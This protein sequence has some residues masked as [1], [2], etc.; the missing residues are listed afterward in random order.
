MGARLCVGLVGRLR[1]RR[2]WAGASAG[3]FPRAHKSGRRA[4]R[5]KALSCTFA[6][7]SGCDAAVARRP[8]VWSPARR[9]S[10]RGRRGFCAPGGPCALFLPGTS[11]LPP[12]VAHTGPNAGTNKAGGLPPPPI[13]SHVT[14]RCGPG[15]G[16]QLKR[17]VS[18]SSSGS[19]DRAGAFCS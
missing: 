10:T 8:Q 12:F 13:G 9:A 6:G 18:V 3:C 2:A 14:S 4:A 11:R 1:G 17:S 5:M 7:G 16:R 15:L 19:R